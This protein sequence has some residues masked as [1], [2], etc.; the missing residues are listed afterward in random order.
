MML[1]RASTLAHFI[2]K[3]RVLRV[4]RAL[5]RCADSPQE[6]VALHGQFA[7]HRD[8]ELPAGKHWLKEAEDTLAMVVNQRA[9]K[10]LVRD[11][12]KALGKWPWERR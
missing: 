10:A 5:W 6:R 7:A 12:V 4:Y 2:H 9:P 11:D 8:A 1:T 3:S